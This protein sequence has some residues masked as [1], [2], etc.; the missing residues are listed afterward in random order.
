MKSNSIYDGEKFS[1]E[2]QRIKADKRGLSEG[3]TLHTRCSGKAQNK[4]FFSRDIKE[5]KASG[6]NA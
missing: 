1:K 3:A 4:W 5:V 6:A 2:N